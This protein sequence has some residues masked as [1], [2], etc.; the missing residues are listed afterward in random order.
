MST[1]AIV[2]L[3]SKTIAG[4][5]A[6]VT[7]IT[8]TVQNDQIKKKLILILL[9]LCQKQAGNMESILLYKNIYCDYHNAS[10]HDKDMTGKRM[11]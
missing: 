2:I 8:R 6:Y 5:K 10:L 7:P 3:I 11:E 1:F 4:L 9:I